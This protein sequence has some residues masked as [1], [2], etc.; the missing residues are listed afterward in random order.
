LKGQ[1]PDYN[2]AALRRLLDG[3][4]GPYRD[5]VLLNASAALIVAGKVQTLRDGASLAARSIDDGA[6]KRALA[7]LVRISNEP[8]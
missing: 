7:A 8:Q 1:G 3:E 4:T 2:A 6:A 5:I